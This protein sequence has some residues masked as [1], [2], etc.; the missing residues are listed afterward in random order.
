MSDA[1]P[2]IVIARTVSITL[3][4]DSM[5]VEFTAYRGDLLW[6][7]DREAEALMAKRFIRRARKPEVE[8]AK[9]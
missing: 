5:P 9:K 2:Y 4:E 1:R 8:E 7:S 3:V 6:L